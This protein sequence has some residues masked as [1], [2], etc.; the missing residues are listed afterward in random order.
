[1]AEH[2]RT[3][4]G[5]TEESITG[6]TEGPKGGRS[7]GERREMREKVRRRSEGERREV[8][9]KVGKRSRRVVEK[10]RI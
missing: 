4:I 6:I 2:S 10:K 5:C 9:V 7:E 3:M 8:R 1:M